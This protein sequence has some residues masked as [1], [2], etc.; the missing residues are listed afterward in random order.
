ME[1]K[2]ERFTVGALK[3]RSDKYIFLIISSHTTS[4]ARFLDASEPRSE[5]KLV[6]PRQQDVEYYPDHHGDQ[7]LIRTNDKGR[8]YRLV[9]RR[10]APGKREL[11]GNSS[12]PA[13]RDAE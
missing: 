9:I 8:T 1:E 12:R 11:E 2:D 3:S 13:G 6:A 7:F 10:S 4:E 5:W